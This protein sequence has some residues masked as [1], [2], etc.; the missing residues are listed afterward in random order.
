MRSVVILAVALTTAASACGGSSK[1]PTTVTPPVSTVRVG[2]CGDP[3]RDGIVGASPS[4][5]HADKDL[6]GDDVDETIVADGDLCNAEGDCHWNVFVPDE[7]A[8]CRRYA[9][10]I[11]AIGIERLPGRGDRGFSDLRAVWA[12]TGDGRFLVQEYR[13]RRG[14]YQVTDALLCRQGTDDQ[15]LC[16]AG[17]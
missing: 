2:D 3:E 4:L 14:G 16:T 9:G 5:R 15:V 8:G 7:L 10:T 12:L 11:Q 1:G 13:F 17:R 6:N